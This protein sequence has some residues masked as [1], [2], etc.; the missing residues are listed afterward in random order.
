MAP[1]V[2]SFTGACLGVARDLAP[3]W[4]RGLLV[5]D[6]P[7]DWRARAAAYGCQAVHADHRRLDRESVAGIVGSGLAVLAYTVNDAARALELRSMGV[8]SVFSDAPQSS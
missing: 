6:V 7:A 5:E 3:A 8:C 4:P 2:S 1:L